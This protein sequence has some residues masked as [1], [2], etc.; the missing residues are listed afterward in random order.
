LEGEFRAC[1]SALITHSEEIAFYKGNQW[2]KKRVNET[3]NDLVQH[4]NNI[5]QKKFYMGVFDSMLVKYGAVMVGYS[6]LGLPVFGKKQITYQVK[7]A[8]DASIITKDYVRNSHLL[9]N[10]AKVLFQISK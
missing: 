2:E 5:H 6:I 9:I 8:N 3:F 10:L 1:H 7:T 4:I